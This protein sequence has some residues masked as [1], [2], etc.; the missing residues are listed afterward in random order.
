MAEAMYDE[1][2]SELRAWLSDILWFGQQGYAESPREELLS[3]MQSDFLDDAEE[4]IETVE[5]SPRI[6]GNRLDQRQWRSGFTACS[7]VTASQ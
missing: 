5:D 2:S 1:K 3:Q 4:S 6:A 7:A